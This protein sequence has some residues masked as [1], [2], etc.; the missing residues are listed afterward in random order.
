VQTRKWTY[1]VWRLPGPYTSS[2]DFAKTCVF[3]KQSPGPFNCGLHCWRRPFSRSYR[4]ILP[5]SLA[6]IHS[7]AS[8]F[9]PWLPVSV[10]GTG[11]IA[12]C[13]EDFLGSLIRYISAQPKPRRTVS[14]QHKQRIS[15]LSVYLLDSTMYSVTWQYFH[16]CVSPSLTI[17]VA[18]Y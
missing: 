16:S 15:L 17:K 13:L 14:I 1:T 8:G 10:C 3:V 6:M 12:I 2:F 5:S 9:S 7:S 4:T 11:F 18:E